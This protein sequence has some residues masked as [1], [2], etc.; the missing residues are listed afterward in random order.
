MQV[1]LLLLVGLGGAL[2]TLL[3]LGISLAALSVL[4][5]HAYLATL[6][7][8]CLGAALIGALSARALPAKL[9]AFAMTGLCGGFT[10][11]SMFSLEIVTLI[12]HSPGVALGY[13][14][15]SA[16]LWLAAAHAG[17]RFGQRR[18]GRRARG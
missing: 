8:N 15:I 1:A 16:V 17:L 12:A 18:A 7:A 9:Q 3:R 11:F 5:D 10:T 4:P 13:G 14:A 6:L 2:G